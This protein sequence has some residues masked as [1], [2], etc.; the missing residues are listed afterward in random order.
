MSN[1]LGKFTQSEIESNRRNMDE[2]IK[3]DLD[4]LKNYDNCKVRSRIATNA[5][6][7]G[8]EMAFG[9]KQQ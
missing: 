1:K 8:W 2:K 6:R 4:F 7:R 3:D 9:R 5:Y